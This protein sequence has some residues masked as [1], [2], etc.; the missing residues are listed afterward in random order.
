MKHYLF[1]AF[2][3]IAF[4]MND[5][6]IHVIDIRDFSVRKIP[7]HHVF[8]KGLQTCD[9]EDTY[10]YEIFSD[11]WLT[12]GEDTLYMIINIMGMDQWWGEVTGY[13]QLVYKL[14]QDDSWVEVCNT[15]KNISCYDD[16]NVYAC[17]NDGEMLLVCRCIDDARYAVIDLKCPN[18]NFDPELE[19]SPMVK[20]EEADGQ[21]H[22]CLFNAWRLHFLKRGHHVYVVNEGTREEKEN[23]NLTTYTCSAVLKS[24]SKILEPSSRT[25]IAFGKKEKKRIEP[26]EYQMAFNDGKSIWNFIGDPA[27]DQ[28]QMT[29]VFVGDNEQLEKREHIPPP[30]SSIINGGAGR[31]DLAQL[32]LTPISEYFY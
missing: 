22:G 15:S 23:T 10:H 32:K 7:F 14:E 9:F 21:Q 20:M 26:C 1:I 6:P 5:T 27:T 25:E 28:S 24:K 12:V 2:Q 8:V 30:F 16:N 18:Q 19:L 4:Q 13:H 29:E 31:L 17:V 11:I 3:N